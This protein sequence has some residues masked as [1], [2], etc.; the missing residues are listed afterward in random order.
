M[1]WVISQVSYCYIN[2]ISG[3]VMVSDA[4]C[5]TQVWLDL[6]DLQNRE[7]QG[8]HIPLSAVPL[9]YTT[10][11]ILVQKQEGAFNDTLTWSRVVKTNVLC[12][13]QTFHGIHLKLCL[14]PVTKHRIRWKRYRVKPLFINRRW[15]CWKCRT[16]LLRNTMAH[17]Q[18]GPCII[19]ILL[20]N[21]TKVS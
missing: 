1:F 14:C 8:F 12:S 19:G 10:Q 6:T 11:A 13:P 4:I 20:L 16:K 5:V 21:E 2:I 17:T 3:S 7:R 15:L 18:V 9:L